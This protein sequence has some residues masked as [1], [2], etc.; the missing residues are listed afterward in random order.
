M[1][2]NTMLCSGR[3][4]YGVQR[5]QDP[6]F[7]QGKKKIFFARKENPPTLNPFTKGSTKM[8]VPLLNKQNTST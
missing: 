7:A 1:L 4:S 6:A 5:K 3:P 2:C 8:L